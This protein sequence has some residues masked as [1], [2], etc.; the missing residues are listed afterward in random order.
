MSDEPDLT[1]ADGVLEWAED[2]GAEMTAAS[3]RGIPSSYRKTHMARMLAAQ[4]VAERIA[5]QMHLEKVQRTFY[6]VEHRA[7]LAEARVSAQKCNEAHAKLH[8][9][10]HDTT[11]ERDE[12]RA[13]LARIGEVWCDCGDR[14]IP[15]EAW[16]PSGSL[17]VDCAHGLA[18]EKDR[19]WEVAKRAKAERDAAIETLRRTVEVLTKMTE[20]V[21]GFGHLTPLS[22]KRIL[23]FILAIQDDEPE[24]A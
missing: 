7:A 12:A 22:Q 6:D 21:K 3:E 19:A 5:R 11:R 4:E 9:V 16:S 13:E 14:L 2:Y 23:P 1:T 20:W 15:N 17:C 10:L 18:S 24:R 8:I